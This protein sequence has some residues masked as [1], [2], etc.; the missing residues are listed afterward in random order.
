MGEIAGDVQGELFQSGSGFVG[1][2]CNRTSKEGARHHRKHQLSAVISEG[3]Q[4]S[5]FRAATLPHFMQ[6][7]RTGRTRSMYSSRCFS[8]SFFF[9]SHRALFPFATVISFPRNPRSHVNRRDCSFIN[10]IRGRHRPSLLGPDR[11]GLF[12]HFGDRRPVPKQRA[13]FVRVIQ[14]RCQRANLA[15]KRGVEG[16]TQ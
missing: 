2:R 13:L 9:H 16:L 10:K 8:I 3:L 6:R 4:R 12:G 1:S 7:Y 5:F 11:A 14:F 15:Q